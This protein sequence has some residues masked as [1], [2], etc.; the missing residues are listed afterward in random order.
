MQQPSSSLS[1]RQEEY[2]QWRARLAEQAQWQE[3]EDTDITV[4][5]E[6][7]PERLFEKPTDEQ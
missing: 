3:P 7:A 1:D 5:P 4:N 6:W 2:R